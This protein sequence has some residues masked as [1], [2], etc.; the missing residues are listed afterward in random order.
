MPPGRGRRPSSP[1][2][3]A[4]A[5]VGFPQNALRARQVGSA[6]VEPDWAPARSPVGEP[7]MV[8]GDPAPGGDAA[9]AFR[10][11]LGRDAGADRR[12]APGAGRRPRRRGDQPRQ[13]R[14]EHAPDRRPARAR[15]RPAAGRAARADPRLRG[16]RRASE[17]PAD[18]VPARLPDRPQFAWHGSLATLR[19]QVDDPGKFAEAVA[20]VS[21]WLFAYVDA[22]VC[23]A[24]EAYTRER[25]RWVRTS[26][27]L[28]ARRSTRSSREARAIRRLRRSVL[29]MNCGA[30]ISRSSG[31]STAP[32]RRLTH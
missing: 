7:R 26:S 15:R 12:R 23:L 10:R 4:G 28:Q 13:Q 6:V 20:L 30:H 11:A 22:A 27:A 2:R 17:H 19:E 25:E 14:G 29:D 3:R 5:L 24:E 8:R 31:G 1:H 32:S 9:R 16:G 21:A 18:R